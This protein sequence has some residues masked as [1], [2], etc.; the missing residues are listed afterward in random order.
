METKAEVITPKKVLRPNEAA[1]Y[2]SVSRSTLYDLCQR[3]E[4]PYVRIGPRGLRILRED[5]DTYLAA[6]RVV[7][8]D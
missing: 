1:E 2:L 5:L 8:V 4:L 7:A 3:R 6:H